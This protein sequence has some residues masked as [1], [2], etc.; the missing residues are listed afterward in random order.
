MVDMFHSLKA[1]QL[2]N[3]LL[4]TTVDHTICSNVQFRV[5]HIPGEENGLADAL[6][7]FDYAH[8]LQLAPSIEIYNFTPPRLVLGAEKL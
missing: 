3:L 7:H 8:I 5:S 1:K 2:Y 4:L 6:S